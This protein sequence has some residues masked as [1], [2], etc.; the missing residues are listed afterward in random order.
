M[1]IP[2]IPAAINY[3]A[4]RSVAQIVLGEP[5]TLTDHLDEFKQDQLPALRT[6]SDRM[7]REVCHLRETLGC[8]GDKLA[9]HGNNGKQSWVHLLKTL[10]VPASSPLEFPGAKTSAVC[11][12]QER[13]QIA[14]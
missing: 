13:R 9:L 14:S 2:L 12:N 6:L 3:A 10:T 8:M 5:L 7:H 11:L 1:N 4:D